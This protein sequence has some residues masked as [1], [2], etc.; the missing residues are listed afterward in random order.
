MA[1]DAGDVWLAGVA[2]LTL[3]LLNGWLWVQRMKSHE[4]RPVHE[5]LEAW[6]TG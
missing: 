1:A 2:M 3:R 6:A 4:A 5:R